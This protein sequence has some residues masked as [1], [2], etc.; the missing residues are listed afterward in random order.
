MW[1]SNAVYVLHPSGRQRVCECFAANNLVGS[2]S[3]LWGVLVP[4]RG[5]FGKMQL[6]VQGVKKKK[7]RQ[8]RAFLSQPWCSA[9]SSLA[10]VWMCVSAAMSWAS[11]ERSRW[12]C[13]FCGARRPVLH[14][15]PEITQMPEWFEI[16]DKNVP[17]LVFV[18]FSCNHQIICDWLCCFRLLLTS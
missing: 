3:S 10:T 2:A 11:S 4:P 6:S 17:S 9:K 16:D 8:N 15:G 7:R 1:I 18:F 12:F 14:L 5:L 13:Y